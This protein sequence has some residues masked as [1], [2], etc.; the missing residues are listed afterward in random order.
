MGLIWKFMPTGCGATTQSGWCGG[1][2]TAPRQT[3]RN[4]TPPPLLKELPQ[5]WTL[6]RV[7]LPQLFCHNCT[8]Q[9]CLHVCPILVKV[10]QDE[11]PSAIP[12]NAKSS[13]SAAV[14]TCR[15][16][17]PLKVV[18]LACDVVWL[19]LS[20]QA[21]LA[22]STTAVISSGCTCTEQMCCNSCLCSYMLPI[23]SFLVWCYMSQIM[24][25]H[26]SCCVLLCSCLESSWCQSCF[27]ITIGWTCPCFNISVKRAPLSL[28]IQLKYHSFFWLLLI[29]LRLLEAPVHVTADHAELSK[30][31]GTSGMFC[32]RI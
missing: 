32:K 5:L 19:W 27:P 3:R 21:V 15:R 28:L 4:K 17:W 16:I 23:W 10:V 18:Q 22:F 25:W 11:M 6:L 7:S 29:M 13:G 30:T 20:M 1:R 24:Q 8:F 9:D 12:W 26:C 14:V 31:R 2:T